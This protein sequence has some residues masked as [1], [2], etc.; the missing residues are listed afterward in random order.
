[1]TYANRYPVSA[2]STLR[3]VQIGTRQPNMSYKVQVYTGAIKSNSA[4]AGGTAKVVTS[5]GAKATSGKFKY[6]GYNTV[7]LSRPVVLKA[8]Q[9]VS[10][11]VTLTAPTGQAAR[12]SIEQSF[13]FGAGYDTL[14]LATGQSFIKSGSKWL[15]MYTVYKGWGALGTYGNFNIIGL[16]SATP[17][18]KVNYMPNGGTVG[19][20]SKSVLFG[21]KVGT[22]ETPIRTG[23][24]F[25]GWYTKASGGTKYTSAKVYTTVTDTNIYAHWKAKKYTVKF[26]A[27]GGTTPKTNNKVTKSKSVTFGKTYGPLPTT[28]RTGYTYGGWYTEQSGGTKITSGTKMDTAAGHTLYAR[29]TPKTYTV[30]F[31][32]RSGT[33]DFASKSVTYN[34]SYGALPGAN[35]PGYDFQGWFTK[36]SGGTQIIDTSKVKITATQTLY[37]RWTPT[38]P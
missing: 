24:T 9:Y 1:V 17:E 8:G 2:E 16:A 31:D 12:A 33:A 18:L 21:T 6:A 34:D 37:A 29:W 10:I 32:P 15:D 7:T 3:A 28:K 38:G 11:V 19:A 26:N 35:R 14:T 20:P 5:G 4:T 27:D 25:T 23:Y 36:T 13:N 22:L 30:K